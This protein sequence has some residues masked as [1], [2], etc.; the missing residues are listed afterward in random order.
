M[1]PDPHFG[2]ASRKSVTFMMDLIHDRDYSVMESEMPENWRSLFNR[3]VE[4]GYTQPAEQS[5][6]GK[7]YR[8][9]SCIL[10]QIDVSL[11]I[12]QLK[13]CPPRGKPKDTFPP[14]SEPVRKVV[15]E[16]GM[17]KYKDDIYKVQMAVHGSGKLY[18][19]KLVAVDTDSIKGGVPKFKFEYAPG[20][21]LLL[22]ADMKLSLEDAMEFGRLYG[23]CCVCGRTLTNELSIHLGIGPVCG[24]REFGGEFEFMLKQAKAEVEAADVNG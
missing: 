19:K 12:D 3:A 5:E 4:M 10:A 8:T 18:A 23:A 22:N 13:K 16:D 6:T 14:G 15:T 20:A 2:G 24:G 9:T 11:F 7:A 1:T 17:Y 21:M